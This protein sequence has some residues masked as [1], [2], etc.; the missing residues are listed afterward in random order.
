MSTSSIATADSKS[1]AYR[2][3]TLGRSSPDPNPPYPQGKSRGRSA[4]R[5]ALTGTSPSLSRIAPDP[6]TVLTVKFRNDQAAVADHTRD[7]IKALWDVHMDPGNFDG[8]WND[9]GPIFKIIIAQHF[10]GS[11]ADAAEYY[12]N[13]KVVHGF[14]YPK[15]FAAPLLAGHVNNMARSVANGSFRHNI[16]KGKEPSAA[17]LSA[18]N[19]F[20]GASARF[21]LNGARNTI[22]NAVA[23]D[24]DVDGWERLIE[25]D[26][27]S[28]CVSQAVKGPFKPGNRGFRAHDNCYCL[29]QP[30]FKGTGMPGPNDQLREEWNRITGTVT[31]RDARD[32]WD[33]YWRENGDSDEGAAGEG[34]GQGP[35]DGP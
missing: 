16:T 3:S 2:D 20:S 12:R 35:G 9:L 22:T 30:V 15:I 26:A 27:C 31:G 23:N 6:P 33:R 18:R 21:V 11:A 17:S 14:S 34:S 10:A 29:A 13:M 4:Y 1:Q 24:P 19:T 8:S 32:L 25:P 28:Y 7:S 5:L